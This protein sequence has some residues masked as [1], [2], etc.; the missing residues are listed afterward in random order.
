MLRTVGHGVPYVY[1]EINDSSTGHKRKPNMSFELGSTA[2]SFNVRQFIFDYFCIS[3]LNGQQLS[4]PIDATIRF[5]ASH[6]LAEC[7]DLPLYATGITEHEA[8]ANLASQIE[9][10][11][12]DL[13]TD[14]NL[15][16]EWLA[17]KRYLNERVLNEKRSV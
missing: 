11:I 9:E 3:E 17:H 14:D 15:S 7:R 5:D 4:R 8:K 13:G 2:K 10:L 16:D 1:G 12:D 6:Y